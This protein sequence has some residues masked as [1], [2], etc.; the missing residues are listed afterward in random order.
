MKRSTKQPAGTRTP[1]RFIETSPQGS[2]GSDRDGTGMAPMPRRA[3]AAAKPAR[4]T[5]VQNK[6]MPVRAPRVPAAPRA[7][8]AA[9]PVAPAGGRKQ[10]SLPT[11]DG[12]RSRP[13]KVTP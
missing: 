10:P 3:R 9:A 6:P 13:R 1:T 2:A 7:S 11:M 12:A 5:P 8:R 4:V